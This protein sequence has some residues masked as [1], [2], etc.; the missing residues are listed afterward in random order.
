MND[1]KVNIKLIKLFANDFETSDGK[2]ELDFDGLKRYCIDCYTID[3]YNILEP[4]FK[5]IMDHLNDI[6]FDLNGDSFPIIEK[7]LSIKNLKDIK[8]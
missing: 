5:K 6:K 7:Y 1:T 4:I 2:W 8:L 3:E